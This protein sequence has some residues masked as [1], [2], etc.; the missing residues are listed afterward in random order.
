MADDN[1]QQLHALI[2]GRVQGVNFRHATVVKA[3][4]VGVTGWVRNVPD[5]TVEVIAEGERQQLE[6]LLDFL[7]IGPNMAEVT[8]VNVE[9]APAS[10]KFANFTMR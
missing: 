10:G 3:R 8:A 9:W 4:E 6:R 5:R 1:V 2:H 7:H